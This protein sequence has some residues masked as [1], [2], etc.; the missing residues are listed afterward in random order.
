M[1]LLDDIRLHHPKARRRPMNSRAMRRAVRSAR[2]V[3][4]GFQILE[5]AKEPRTRRLLAAAADSG[6]PP[7]TAIS[8]KL[9]QFIPAKDAKLTPLKQYAGLCVRAVLEEEGFEIADTGVRVSKDP[10]FKSGATY[11]RVQAEKS[12]TP[13]LLVRLILTLTEEEKGEALKLL[14]KGQQ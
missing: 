2:A 8:G 5:F 6:V 11:R 1:L 3:L 4:H 9:L 10:I 13:A 12:G 7:V 14:G